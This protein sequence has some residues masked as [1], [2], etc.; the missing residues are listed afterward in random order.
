MSKN[1]SAIFDYISM[2]LAYRN[3]KDIDEFFWELG[4]KSIMECVNDYAEAMINWFQLLLFFDNN[5]DKLDK[6][7]ED[8]YYD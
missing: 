1:K 6:F 3:A 7:L 4:Y 2:A 5:E 8:Y